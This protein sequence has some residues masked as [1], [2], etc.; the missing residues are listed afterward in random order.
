MLEIIFTAS[1]MREAKRLT[2]LNKDLGDE[3][4]EKIELFRNRRNHKK[5]KVHKLRGNLAGFW[6]FSVNYQYRIIFELRSR[7]EVIFHDV[8]DH[9]VY[10]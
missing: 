3:I 10:R 4:A 2:K 6:S 5:L 7:N 8:G 1:F 9:D